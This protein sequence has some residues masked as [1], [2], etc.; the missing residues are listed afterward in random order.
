MS[1]FGR[2]LKRGK[3]DSQSTDNSKQNP[4]IPCDRGSLRE[5]NLPSLAAII[6]TGS[7]TGSD[8]ARIARASSKDVV[9]LISDRGSEKR[10]QMAMKLSHEFAA[11][12]SLV[13]IA[14]VKGR[15]KES[16]PLPS[17]PPFI[18]IDPHQSS[19]LQCGSVLIRTSFIIQHLN[20]NMPIISLLVLLAEWIDRFGLKYSSVRV[21]D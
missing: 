1:I 5:N 17:F 2:F 3:K 14:L 7:E 6:V 10:A 11:D 18:F 13:F 8:I 20:D 15:V 16:A 21:N 9:Y 4:E 12:P 19:I